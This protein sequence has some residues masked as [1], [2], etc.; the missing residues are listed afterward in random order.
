MNGWMERKEWR[1][2]K[3]RRRRRRK[4]KTRMTVVRERLR[5][6]MRC[7]VGADGASAVAEVQHRRWN[8]GEMQQVQLK[9][10]KGRLV[11]G[12]SKW[13]QWKP[14][15]NAGKNHCN[16]QNLNN[17]RHHNHQHQSDWSQ[18]W[19]GIVWNI[20]WIHDS[21]ISPEAFEFSNIFWSVILPGKQ[22]LKGK[23]WVM[24]EEMEI[25]RT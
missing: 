12:S 6:R 9:A 21:N 4:R 23:I 16:H 5:M 19:S 24:T 11:G 17:C 2:L 13:Q 15:I 7:S 25:L 22:K 3:S 14:K 8:A 10:K 1:V 18:K 20:H